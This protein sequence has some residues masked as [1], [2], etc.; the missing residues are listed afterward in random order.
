MEMLLLNNGSTEPK[1]TVIATMMSLNGLWD[2]GIPGMCT[3]SDLYERC[4]N[5]KHPIADRE[6]TVL[7]NLALIQPDGRI[8][9]S[10]KNIVLSAITGQSINIKMGSPIKQISSAGIP[11]YEELTS[12]ADNIIGVRMGIM[13][14]V[15]HH[16][17]SMEDI[18][19]FVRNTPDGKKGS[20]LWDEFKSHRDKP[21]AQE[22]YCFADF[23]KEVVAQA[24]S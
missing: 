7:K 6:F 8:H 18:G 15:D 9:D 17:V 12:V 11:T 5:P 4:C 16:G 1:P 3:V 22:G 23:I 19:T 10:I 20:D 21:G 14:A 13:G 2:K 24:K